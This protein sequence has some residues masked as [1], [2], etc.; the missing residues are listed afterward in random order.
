MLTVTGPSVS[1]TLSL[2]PSPIPLP[3]AGLI[4]RQ[5]PTAPT[6]HFHSGRLP[7]YAWN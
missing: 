4:G 2:Y 1:C 3:V 5:N 6:I 7:S